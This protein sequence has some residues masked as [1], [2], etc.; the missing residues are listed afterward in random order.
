MSKKL[1]A[2]AGVVASLAVA[3]APLATFAEGQN[4]DRT[5][6]DNLEV[7]IEPSCAFGH[8]FTDTDITDLDGAVRTNGTAAWED[9]TSGEA[10]TFTTGTSEDTASAT[11]EAGTKATSFATTAMTVYCNNATGYQVKLTATNL[12]SADDS[13]HPIVP[14]GSTS[15]ASMNVATDTSSRYNITPTLTSATS[16]A[17]ATGFTSAAEAT[18]LDTTSSK[19]FFSN[20]GATDNAGDVV[21]VV[22]GVGLI[23]TQG[24]GTYTGSVTYVLTQGQGS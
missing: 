24:A 9:T 17:M 1:I 14:A 2:G 10:S 7:T 21:S 6:V 20:A 4:T 15:I 5:I 3:L 11:M 19:L 16:A 8:D 23:K 13:A 12:A 18:G 22:Y